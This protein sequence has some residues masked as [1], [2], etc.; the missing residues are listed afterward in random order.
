MSVVSVK[1]THEGRGGDS[2]R[3]SATL[4]RVFKVQTDSVRDGALVARDAPGIPALGDTYFDG[5]T[6]NANY[7]AKNKS[8]T[9]E[10]GSQKLWRVEV[11]YETRT[12]TSGP[13][14]ELIPPLRAPDYSWATGSSPQEMLLDVNGKVVQNSAKQ[15]FDP[16]VE[17]NNSF[18][19]LTIGRNEASF[20]AYAMESYID[21]LNSTPIFGYAAREGRIDAIDAVVEYDANYGAY[22]RV[23]YVIHFR[24]TS[25]WAPTIA[26]DHRLWDISGAPTVDAPAPGPWD[27]TR[28]NVG[29]TYL[30]TTGATKPSRALDPSGVFLSDPVDLEANGTL[31]ATQVGFTPY[32]WIFY[33]YATMSW[34]PLRLDR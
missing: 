30:K 28:R 16:A 26:S 17:R 5:T 23:T 14:P 11:E 27:I 13:D 34:F 4:R 31:P 33:P 7:L 20:N 1:E 2:S 6:E 19:I 18:R 25:Q 29:T 9:N 12:V 32:W 21:T 24:K 22:W 8:A 3:D 15:P 10:D